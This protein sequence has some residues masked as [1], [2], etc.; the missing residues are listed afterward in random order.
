MRVSR[1]EIPGV[2]RGTLEQKTEVLFAYLFGSFA[3]ETT[4]RDLDVGIFIADLRQIE[5]TLTYTLDLSGE[6]ERRTGYPVDVILMNTAPDHLIYS[7]AKGMVLVDRDEN[8]RV[9]WIAQAWKR[10]LDVKPK[11]RQAI[12]DMMT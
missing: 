4:F 12:I 6:L 8:F 5:N 11:R 1:E 9:D 2:L 10:Y 3:D 7:I